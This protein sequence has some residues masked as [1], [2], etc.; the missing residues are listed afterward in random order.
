MVRKVTKTKA[1]FKSDNAIQK[2]FHLAT[3]IAQT[4][5][6]GA[7]SPKPSLRKDL[8]AYFEDRFT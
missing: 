5:R 8:I 7:Y 4:K 6:D 1:A 2:Q 3:I